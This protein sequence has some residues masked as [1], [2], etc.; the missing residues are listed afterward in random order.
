ME[1]AERSVRILLHYLIAGKISFPCFIMII[2]ASEN[3]H[4]SPFLSLHFTHSLVNFVDYL[5][6]WRLLNA[7][8]FQEAFWR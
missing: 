5:Y 2:I 8:I 4:A 6:L 7:R 1:K 3:L